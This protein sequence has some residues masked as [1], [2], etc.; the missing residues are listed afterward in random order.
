[1][2]L[3]S[4]I[5]PV[6]NGEQTIRE[7]IES[8]LEQTFSDFELLVIDDGSHDST[9]EI[10]SHIKDPRLKVFSYPNAG[11][12][13]SRNRGIAHA[14]GEY[15]SFIDADDLWTSD[16]LESQFRRLQENPEAALAYSW[17]DFIDES[18][19]FVR[20]G[21]HLTT[22]GDAYA[23]LLLIN[24]LENGSNPLIRREALNQVGGFDE[25]LTASED[26][27]LWLR[28]AAHYNFITIS[29]PQI[30]YRISAN[31]MT[32]NV[33]K[34]ERQTLIVIEQAFSQ[35]PQSLQYL[36]PYSISNIYKYLT[37]KALEGL[38]ERQKGV[39]AA[40]FFW[41]S[42]INDPSLLRTRVI[43]KVL[44]RVAVVV[45]LPP[46]LTKLLL[47]NIKSLF[48]INALLVHIKTKLPSK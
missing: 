5:I 19:Q 1:M 15:I 25:S 28:L 14:S 18:S 7:T 43:W 29:Y 44:L 46:K 34:Q 48:D 30:L 33:A 17:T 41:N 22:N 11:L 26:W 8:V 4:V 13:V 45:V 21:S 23:N 3:I 24:F 32:A 9:L 39:L 6:Y 40:R 27:D 31:S 36:K 2:P 37:V 38:P 42:I 35:A 20:T 16:K 12:A 10:I 47:N